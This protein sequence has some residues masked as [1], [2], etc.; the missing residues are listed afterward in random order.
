MQKYLQYFQKI[1]CIQ[2]ILKMGN[3][4][5]KRYLCKKSMQNCSFDKGF[6]K[7]YIYKNVEIQL[8]EVR[9]S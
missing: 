6:P 1:K 3:Y 5:L 7:S 2:R 4:T 8:P 9:L